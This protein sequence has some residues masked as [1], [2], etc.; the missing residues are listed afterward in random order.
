MPA[1]VGGIANVKLAERDPYVP[2][3]EAFHAQQV[4][5]GRRPERRITAIARWLIFPSSPVSSYAL[6][7]DR[8]RGRA[9]RSIT[10]AAAQ[11]GAKIPRRSAST[12]KP[13][14]LSVAR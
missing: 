10:C 8:E 5:P 2:A 6:A 11:R 13:T 12:R 9:Q 4:G 14:R 7:D 1:T 3:A